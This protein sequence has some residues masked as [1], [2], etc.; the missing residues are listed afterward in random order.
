MKYILVDGEDLDRGKWGGIIDIE[1]ADPTPEEVLLF[2]AINRAIAAKNTPWAYGEVSHEAMWVES[3]E[4]FPF[5]GTI[6]D[7]VQI[8]VV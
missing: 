3:F 5:T 8:F 4:T 7:A 6:E 2:D 1:K